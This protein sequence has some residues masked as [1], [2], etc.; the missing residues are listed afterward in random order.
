MGVCIRVCIRRA[1]DMLALGQAGGG[2]AQMGR[3]LANLW[4]CW[5][6]ESFGLMRG[7]GGAVY[8]IINWF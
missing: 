1:I 2:Q 8:N 5:I 6:S 4:R 3:T 7:Q